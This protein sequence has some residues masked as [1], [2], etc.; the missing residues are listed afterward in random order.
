MTAADQRD[1]EA[2][3][4]RGDNHSVIANHFAMMPQMV[5]EH[6]SCKVMKQSHCQNMDWLVQKV[7]REIASQQKL[8]M[9]GE[10]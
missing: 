4:H 9:T 6:W 3:E 7:K 10:D 8:A 5:C 2:K 1:R